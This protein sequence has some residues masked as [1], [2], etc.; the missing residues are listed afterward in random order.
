M[1]NS[2]LFYLKKIIKKIIYSFFS[3]V[4]KGT[5]NGWWKNEEE[6]RMGAPGQIAQPGGGL[7]Y[8]I[9]WVFYR[10][11]HTETNHHITLP[12]A[13][14]CQVP[15]ILARARVCVCVCVCLIFIYLA[16][17]GLTCGMRNL[18]PWPGIEPRPPALEARSLNCWTTREVRRFP[19]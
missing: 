7:G 14:Q 8:L 9:Y 1:K 19:F 16:A 12:G 6:I 18:V 4:D 17:L 3:W 11:A 13:V 5:T 10:W 2:T 15:I